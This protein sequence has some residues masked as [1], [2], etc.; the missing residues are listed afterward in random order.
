MPSA[1]HEESISHLEDDIVRDVE[2]LVERL[3]SFGQQEAVGVLRGVRK[4]RHTTVKMSP[5]SSG[6]SS[7]DDAAGDGKER[8]SIVE[9]SPDATFFFH[10]HRRHSKMPG[11]VVEGGLLAA[12]TGP[13]RAR[14]QLYCGQ[15][16][17]H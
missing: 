11:L 9:R 12:K 14:G 17:G 4:G 2:E 1:R 8:E 10:N 7:G 13:L 15:Q 5:L 16:R 3:G 6:G